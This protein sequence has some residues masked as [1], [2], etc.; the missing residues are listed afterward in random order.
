MTTDAA[1]LA[2]LTDDGCPHGADDHDDAAAFVEEIN[3]LLGW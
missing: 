3:R 2:R 1:D